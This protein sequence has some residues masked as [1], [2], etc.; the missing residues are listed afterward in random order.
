MDKEQPRKDS[1]D[2]RTESR[3]K[4][5]DSD[6][7]DS[8]ADPEAQAARMLEESDQRTDEASEREEDDDSIERRTSAEASGLGKG[9]AT[10]DEAE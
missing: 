1:N 7:L 9:A 2:E 5:L 4:T 8:V 3:A 6:Q 10:S